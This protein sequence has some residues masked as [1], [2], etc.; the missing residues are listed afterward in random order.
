MTLL[1]GNK[2]RGFTFVEIMVTITI[3]STGIVMIYKAFLISLDQQNYLVHR[4][5]ANNL[6]DQK[7]AEL[8]RLFQ[9]RG[10]DALKKEGLVEDVVIH[11]KQ[12]PFEIKTFFEDFAD[13]PDLLELNVGVFWSEHGRPVRLT[14]VAYIS[15]Y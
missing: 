13:L 1:T 9:E 11:N 14:R 12:V 8:G 3:L 5:Y 6:L 2:R 15:R 7:I 10:K 4:L